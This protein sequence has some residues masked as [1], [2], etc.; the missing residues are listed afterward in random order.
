MRVSSRTVFGLAVIVAVGLSPGPYWLLS[1]AESAAAAETPAIASIPVHNDGNS[2]DYA[3]SAG[4][5]EVLVVLDA[6]VSTLD[7]LSAS[8]VRRVDSVTADVE[9]EILRLGGTVTGSFDGTPAV[10][11]L[12]S[13]DEIAALARTPGVA[14]VTPELAVSPAAVAPSKPADPRLTSLGVPKYWGAAGSNY[15]VAVLD[16][17]V[18][19]THPA[20]ASK[21]SGRACFSSSYIP[22]GSISLCPPQG[23]PASE[24]GTN[25]NVRNTAN[26]LSTQCKH[27]TL[28]AGPAVSAPI[29]MQG[30]ANFPGGA[31]STSGVA[32]SANLVPV[33]VFSAFPDCRTEDGAVCVQSLS[34]DVIRSLSWLFD[35]RAALRLGAVNMS[36][37]GG[38]GW[39]GQATCRDDIGGV[40]IRRLRDAGIP[41][42]VAAGNDYSS[43]QVAWPA[44]VSGAVAV[45][46]SQPRPSIYGGWLWGTLDIAPFSNGGSRIDVI[47]PGD[48]VD[49]TSPGNQWDTSA[50]TSIAAPQVAGAAALWKTY[51]PSEPVSAF[52]GRVTSGT[53]TDSRNG[54]SYP[55]LNVTDLVAST[56]VTTTTAPPGA[57]TTTLLPAFNT[58][59]PTVTVPPTL[60]PPTIPVSIPNTPPDPSTPRPTLPPWIDAPPMQDTGSRP[61]ASVED[62]SVSGNQIRFSGWAFDTDGTKPVV[63]ITVNGQWVWMP[64]VNVWRPDLWNFFRRSIDD[65]SG[66][67]GAVEATPG[68]HS[69]CAHVADAVTPNAFRVIDCKNAVVK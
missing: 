47:A 54:L 3:G 27:G 37:G 22:R 10:P 61:L 63:L 23:S 43:S 2:P 4:D 44:C 11:A 18:D 36:L 7:G 62:V 38:L 69:V 21:V 45:A 5:V 64:P 66:W 41:V 53:V 56:P 6:G 46:A 12:L 8:E 17:G 67:S 58:V 30:N 49:T 13:R 48:S 51:Y 39:V 40:E 42:V 24:I 35:N 15:S 29:D 16:T 19:T 65:H 55:R 32:P 68:T 9:A 14:S 59:P 50:G 1:S 60:P 34:G 57:P 26:A 25:C 31:F 28:V 33:Q 52:L 20:F